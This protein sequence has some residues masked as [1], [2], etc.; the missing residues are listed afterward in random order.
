MMRKEPTGKTSAI[1]Y[2]PVALSEQFHLEA[3]GLGGQFHCGDE[4]LLLARDLLLL[5][6]DLLLALHH[7]DLHLLRADLL[8]NLG[9]LQLVRQLGVRFLSATKQKMKQ[10]RNRFFKIIGGNQDE[11]VTKCTRRMQYQMY[12]AVDMMYVLIVSGR[13][14]Y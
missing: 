6:L 9:R 12:N 11:S 13:E 14:S 2:V 5:D 3:L 1:C 7:R 8:A 4:L 10:I